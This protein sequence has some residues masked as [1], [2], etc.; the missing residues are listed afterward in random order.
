MQRNYRCR[1]LYVAQSF[2]IRTTY[3]FLDLKTLIPKFA[4]STQYFVIKLIQV[5]FVQRVRKFAE[6]KLA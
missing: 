1:K 3:K 5:I 6:E 2:P 4:K